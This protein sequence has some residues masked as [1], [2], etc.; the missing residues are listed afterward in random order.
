MLHYFGYGSSL[1]A[2]SLRAEGVSPLRSESAILEGWS[3]RFDVPDF[4]A[5]EGGTANVAPAADD[6]VHGALYACRDHDLAAIDRLEGAG[7]IRERLEVSVL[8]YG[9][10]RKLAYVYV[11]LPSILDAGVRPSERY[12]NLLV[13]GAIELG[14]EPAYVDRL[15]ALHPLPP[16]VPALFTASSSYVIGGAPVSRRLPASRRGVDLPAP[17]AER[18][19]T[20]AARSVLLKA[21]ATREARGNENLGFLSEAYG[22]LPREPP[23]RRLP[24]AFAA[25]D[26]IAEGLPDLYR[27]LRLRREIESLPVLDAGVEALPDGYL[28]RASAVLAMLSHA[29]H[30]V[31]VRPPPGAPAALARPWEEVRRRLGGGPAVLSYIDLVVYNWMLLDPSRSDPM[32][33]DNLRLLIP[34]VDTDEERVFYLTQ[35]EILAHATPIIGAVVRAQEAV[36]E[37]DREAIESALLTIIGCLE[38]IVRESLLNIDPNPSGVTH[39][40]PV[41]WAKTVAPFA[42]PMIEGVQGPSGTSSP[43]FNTLDIFLGRK[44]FDTFLGKEIHALRGTYPPLWREFLAALGEISVPDYIVHSGDRNLKGLLHETVAAYTGQ[45]GFLG[46]HRMK[47]YGYLELAFKVGRSVTI[48]GFKGVFKD[49]TWDQVDTE[50]EQSRVERAQ[51]FPQSCHHVRVKSVT[52]EGG[53]GAEPVSHVV[54]DISSTGTWYEP[55]DRCGIL[56]ENSPELIDRTLVALGARGDERMLLTRE[57]RDAVRLRAGYDERATTMSLRHVLRFGRIRPVLPRVAEALHA[58]SQNPV[59]REHILA[60]TTHR[61]ELWDLLEMLTRSGFDPRLLWQAGDRGT[62]DAICRIIPPEG[63]RMYSI[64]STMISPDTSV[65]QELHLTVGRLRYASTHADGTTEIARHGAASSFLAAAAGRDAPISIIIEHPPRF[66]LPRSA[67]TP[68]ILVAGGTGI[69]PFRGFLAE[70]RR[71]LGAG[72][73]WLFLGLRSRD[74]FSY[75]E[76]L[77]PAVASGDLHLAVS[78]SRDDVDLSFA[79]DGAGGGVFVPVP[80]KR[81]QVQDMLV[82]EETARTVW[83][84]L[85]RPALGGTKASVFICGRSGFARSVIDA[86]KTIFARFSPGDEEHERSDVAQQLLCEL[87]AEGRL[88]LEI[89]S[90]HTEEALPALDVSAIARRN[91]EGRGYWLVIEG[92]V[93]DLTEFIRLHPGGARILRGYAGMDAT[94]GY[95]RSHTGRSEVDAMRAMYAIGTVRRLDLGAFSAR[96][97]GRAGPQL[98]SLSAAYR[99]WVKLLYLVVEM[100]NALAADHAL[101]DGITA[102]GDPV[103]PRSPYKLQRAVET[104]ERFLRSYVELLVEE[105]LPNLWAITQGLFAPDLPIDWM[106]GR[107]NEIAAGRAA[108]FADGMVPELFDAVTRLVE[109]GEPADTRGMIATACEVLEQEDARLIEEAKDLLITGVE[110]FEELETETPLRGAFFL[111][112]A[113]RG[114]A[115]RLQRYYAQSMARL[116]EVDWSPVVSERSTSMRSFTPARSRTLISNPHWIVE[117]DEDDRIV[118]LRRTP[119][120]FSAVAEIVETNEAVISLFRP[121]HRDFGAVVDMRQAP[122]RN[123]PDFEAAMRR[124]RAVITEQFVRVAVLVDSQV[125]VLQVDRLGR[126][127]ERETLATQSEAATRRFARCR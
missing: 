112:A 5:L 11:G 118:T 114:L 108:R 35:T 127:D 16:V 40:D 123:D 19:V 25:W 82:E 53:A 49:R 59:L 52:L 87:M 91:D 78:F 33:I 96:V 93:L 56:P 39:V 107:L 105:S 77:A 101:Q 8:T 14:L 15:R 6:A 43:I 1:G 9:G 104:H 61:W 102:R 13:R 83:E 79:P 90:G 72:P 17:R 45:N 27:S 7:T 74:H 103:R 88:M 58:V 75:A 65:E 68:I 22:F 37:Q 44:K 89:F 67:R 66:S 85:R 64:S 121:E 30:Y 109:R 60:R 57:W 126:F 42:V 26:Q 10:R 41:V 29:Y 54:L 32:R 50:L 55:G 120:P 117:E 106:R 92:Q 18:S 63:F 98:V 28:H 20:S 84:L 12:R 86:L 73:A 94:D 113:C 99:V 23:R 97:E 116:G 115:D 70:R 125:G 34:T 95:A 124:L 47:V 46:R 36:V 51:A 3:L 69:S 71:Q 2:A 31:E 62:P 80:G 119:T 24:P 122:T 38:R 21:D 48:G 110:V 100:Q 81:R 111:V 4:F 76:E